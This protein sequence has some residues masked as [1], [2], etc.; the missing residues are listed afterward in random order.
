M[1]MQIKICQAS[2]ILGIS[3]WIAVFS[4]ALSLW[5]GERSIAELLSVLSTGFCLGFGG[6][7]PFDPVFFAL[8]GIKYLKSHREKLT[9]L[10]QYCLLCE[11]IHFVISSPCFVQ[12][13][14]C[15]QINMVKTMSNRLTLEKS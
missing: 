11:I 8:G 2:F 13:V 9:F 5:S 10:L 7:N 6:K 3:E 14:H 12:C 4:G 15:M 1:G